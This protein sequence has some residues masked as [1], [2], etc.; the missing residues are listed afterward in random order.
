MAAMQQAGH[1]VEIASQLRSFTSTPEAGARQQVALQAENEAKRL[2]TK[3][4]QGAKPDLWF[5]YHPYYKA[6]DL[7]GPKLASSFNLPYVT[8][9]ASYSRRRDE[10]GWAELQLLVSDAVRQAVVNICFTKRDEAGL[11]AAVPAVHLARLAPF[12][13]V[14]P[15]AREPSVQRAHRLVTVAM[16]RPGDK[17]ESY[18]MLAAALALIADLPWTLTVIGDGP[19]R[20][21]VRAMFAKFSAGRIEWLGERPVTEVVHLLY[22]GGTYVWP[23]TGEAYGIAYMEAQ[24]AGLP[25][26]AQKTAGVPEVVKDGVTGT[27]TPAGDT[28]A[29]AHAIAQ[30]LADGGRR[31]KMGWAARRFILQDRSLDVASRRLGELLRNFTGA[32]L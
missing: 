2:A 22:E 8:A 10:T 28:L 11:A 4:R 3:W 13:D 14:L 31:N 21:A 30:M 12:I 25:V 32:S 6:P 9:E 27:L 20:D 23:G 18:S 15:F 19:A 17:L 5:C 7:I 1:T 24:A 26:V 16:M 29:F